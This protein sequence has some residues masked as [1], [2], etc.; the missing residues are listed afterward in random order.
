MSLT[1]YHALAVCLL[2]PLAHA[3]TPPTT[4]CTAGISTNF[5]IPQISANTQPNAAN[6]SGC[7]ITTSGLPGQRKGVVFYGV[8]NFGFT[9]TPWGVGGSS[10]LCV[11]SPIRRVGGSLNSGGTA[12]SC[13]GAYVIDWGAFQNANPGALGNP[14]VPGDKVF[15][16]SWY[17]DSLALNTSNLSNALELTLSPPLPIPCISTIPG[18]VVIP[19]GTF[20]QGSN[21]PSGWPYMGEANTTPVHPVTISYCFWMGATE[22]TQAQYAALMGTNPSYSVDPGRPVDRVTWFDANAYCAALT[23]QE[24]ALGNVPYGFQY[25]LPTEAEWEYACRAG[26]TTEFNVGD[27]LSCYQAAIFYS[28]H[29]PAGCSQWISTAPVL[30]YAPNGWGLYEMHGNVWEW[31]LDSYASYSAGAVTDPFVTGGPE[32]VQRGGSCL[33]WSSSCRSA[34]RGR[35]LSSYTYRDFGF[36]VVL[37]PVLVP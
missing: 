18:M 24:S 3:Q 2:V 20:A 25:R 12:G 31:C 27:E 16:Q 37:A 7:V 11:K 4:Y 15:V 19:A 5:C 26:T 14:W 33:S 21:A 10:F 6:N 1:T 36:R 29:D 13:N 30:S 22:V 9:P 23:A 28:Y 8:D 32:R 34:F 35:A 17:R